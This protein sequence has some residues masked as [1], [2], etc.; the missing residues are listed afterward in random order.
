MTFVQSGMPPRLPAQDQCTPLLEVAPL[1][2]PGMNPRPS[3]Q[4]EGGGKS[5]PGHQ[6]QL[7]L[8]RCE[9]VN[10]GGWRG[11]AQP[12]GQRTFFSGSGETE[13]LQKQWG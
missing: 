12:L 9:C 8:H 5:V 3:G 4:D 10:G 2:A 11:G 13:A 1:S 7:Q 6:Q